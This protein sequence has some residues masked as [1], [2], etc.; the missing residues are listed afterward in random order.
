M[1]CPALVE[2]LPRQ[3]K[4]E[5]PFSFE[6]GFHNLPFETERRVRHDKIGGAIGGGDVLPEVALF[7]DL[8]HPQFR[9]FCTGRTIAEERFV[10]GFSRQSGVM[11]EPLP[12]C[13]AG[14]IFIAELVFVELFGGEGDAVFRDGDSRFRDLL[15]FGEVQFADNVGDFERGVDG[16]EGWRSRGEAWHNGGAGTERSRDCDP[17]NC[18]Y[19]SRFW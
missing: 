11:H 4:G 12:R 19:I 17:F 5:R 13:G 8:G 15:H 18:E 9:E 14:V 6:E 10:D 7:S 16:T 2:G 3:D 1:F